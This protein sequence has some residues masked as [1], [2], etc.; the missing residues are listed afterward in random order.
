MR[1]VS[2]FAMMMTITYINGVPETSPPHLWTIFL[3]QEST[4]SKIKTS[5]SFQL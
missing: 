1:I 4:L 2:D 3:V 5:L